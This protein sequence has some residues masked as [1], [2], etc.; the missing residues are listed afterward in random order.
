MFRD[1]ELA[2]LCQ[3]LGLSAEARAVIEAIR[4]SPPARRVR[5]AAGN[6]AVRY[7]SRKM[8]VTIQ[9]ESHRVELAGLYEYEHDPATLEFYDQPPPIK[10]VYEAREGRQVAVWHTP[11]YFVLRT[12]AVGWEE[13]KTEEGLERLTG[14]MPH[15]YVRAADGRWQ[16]PPGERY[17]SPRGFYYRVRSSA[18]IDWVFQRNLL[19]LEDYLR[20]DGPPVDADAAAAIL[21]RVVQ[22]PGLPLAEMLS[23]L[24]EASSD[25]I[26]ALIAQG[27]LYVDLHA[28]ALA[29][30]ERVA[31][32]RDAA[33]ARGWATLVT[34]MPP[35]EDGRGVPLLPG[36]SAPAP[37]AAP[38]PP[39]LSAEA[40]ER[41]A[42]AS[43]DDYGE[44]NR[45][46][47]IIA[48]RLAGG[49]PADATP[50]RTVRHWLAQYRH[51]E[52]AHCCGYVGLLPRRAESGNRRRKLPAATLELLEAFIANDYETLK[53]K[54]KF[55][56]YAALVRACAARG[57]I[58]L[59]YKTFARA[60][61]RRPRQ[62]Q[63]AK[64]QGP[65]AAAQAASFH[66]ELTLTT[67]RHGDRPFEIGHLDHTQLDVELV[68]SR[69]GRN[70]GR[71]WA[72]FLSDAYSRRLLAVCLAFDPPSYRACLLVLRECVRRH[73]R[74]P[75][76]VV[77]D[78]GGEFESVYFEALLARY[79]C[80]KKT[81][82]AAQLRFGS[83]CERLFGTTNT[84]FVHT[85]GGDTQLTRS[86]R[87]VT[88]AV[89]PKG[90][91]RWTLA[92]LDARLCEWAYE[93]YD[94]LEHPALG[95]SPREAFAA[96]LLRGGQRP[97]RRIP[98][99]EDF[100]LHTLPTT[101]KGTA[102]LQPRLGIKLHYLYYWADA[103]LD[104]A[105]EGTQV[106]VRY[107]PFDAGQ[108]YA[109]VQGRWVR[110]LSEHHARFAGRS[111]REIQLASA[112]LRRRH[113]RHGQ[114]LPLT[115]R[116]LADFLASV[117]AEEL[118]W[119]QRLRDAAARDVGRR[120]APGPAAA[121][122][123]L[124]AVTAAPGPAGPAGGRPG[125][126]DAALAIY[127]DY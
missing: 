17:A 41:L 90:Q 48:P 27:R 104:P 102:K 4:S 115:A 8:G 9:A 15:R 34:A 94:T 62:E 97:Q 30:P 29:E 101:R 125:Q 37:L 113:Q 55:A 93:I 33:T 65:R 82:P 38:A 112:E 123:P 116:Q 72:T 100:R 35:V 63:V 43:P 77:V 44:A 3:H 10:L 122:A 80:T 59:S 105:V 127:E 49:A 111:E 126:G 14:T 7:P 64:R 53:Q 70:L 40:R 69:T 103:F 60:A 117:E 86:R 61:E 76:T 78:G 57:V 23:Q 74:L 95:Q 110:C 54:G 85:L 58:A 39:D 98:Y 25:D 1:H 66:W 67:P 88:K 73:E 31:L 52:Q 118:L 2:A 107:D 119:E 89:D 18:E 106:P 45:R 42:R 22:Q 47:A 21:A 75:Q 68:C 32:F 96:G 16:C 6:V 121:A 109:F 92:R 124:A 114:H 83:V 24:A 108:A 5:S 91:A 36:G 11:D 46:Y 19:F 84:R 81:R 51:A 99:D 79:E 12:D 28:A 20:A 56:V 120:A 26:Y 50:A 71:P 13:W 87:Q